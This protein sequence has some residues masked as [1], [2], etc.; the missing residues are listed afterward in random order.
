[1]MCSSPH[2]RIVRPRAG[3]PPP[4]EPWVCPFADAQVWVCPNGKHD[5]VGEEIWQRCTPILRSV[6]F[7]F[8]IT[9]FLQRRRLQKCGKLAR[10]DEWPT[11]LSPRESEILL[12]AL[13]R[14]QSSHFRIFVLF[15]FQ[16]GLQRPSGRVCRMQGGTK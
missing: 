14:P 16:T 9:W 4:P 15:Q 5:L 6:H 1:M 8:T 7:T 2:L 12:F 3:E 11:S 10:L 13:L